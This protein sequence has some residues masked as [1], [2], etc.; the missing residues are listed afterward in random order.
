MQMT[1]EVS[2]LRPE[3]PVGNRWHVSPSILVKHNFGSGR[4]S[5]IR[6]KLLLLMDGV[7]LFALRL[8]LRSSVLRGL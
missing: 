3:S 7:N 6:G 8:N 1:C 5:E 2:K 4:P